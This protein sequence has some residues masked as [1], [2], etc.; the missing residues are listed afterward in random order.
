ML[1]NNTNILKRAQDELDIHIGRDRHVE[2]S[3]IKN[4]VYLHAIV[5]E[6][7]RLYPA[8]P[9]SVPHEAMEDCQVGGYHVPKGTHLLMNIWKLHRDPRVWSDPH[10]FRPERFLTTHA[11][12][13]VWGKHFEYIPFGSGRRACPGIAFAVQVMHLTLARLLHGY[14]LMSHSNAPV[15]M[16]E[17]LGL[18]LPRAT[19]LEAHLTPRL[20]SKL[21]ED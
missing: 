2:E 12:V 15:D 5:K 8:G 10:E 1:L 17:G 19:S 20:P 18:T 4:L 3:D 13:D 16:S 11:D 21:Y 7:M 9:L 14:N 6:T